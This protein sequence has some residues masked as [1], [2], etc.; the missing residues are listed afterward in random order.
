[1]PA[2]GEVTELE[3]AH[4]RMDT[5]QG[6]YEMRYA[7]FDQ[8]AGPRSKGRTFLRRMILCANSRNKLDHWICITKEFRS[9]LFW[10]HVYIQQWNGVSF[11]AA[12][13]HRPPDYHTFTDASGSWGC[14][15]VTDQLWF[16]CPWSPSWEGVN[17]ATKELVPIVLAVAVGVRGDLTSML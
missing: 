7:L 3:K 16:H 15:A 8:R 1:M 17:I 11:L 13:V 14:G 12:H 10:W 9:D 6:C 2:R 4:R 5:E